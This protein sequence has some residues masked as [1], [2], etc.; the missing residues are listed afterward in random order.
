MMMILVLDML[1]ETFVFS[2][3][4]IYYCQLWG[5]N[6]NGMTETEQECIHKIIIR[7]S[8]CGS[9]AKLISGFVTP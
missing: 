9:V 2:L 3:I 4:P 6:S 1:D 5:E 8:S 7:P